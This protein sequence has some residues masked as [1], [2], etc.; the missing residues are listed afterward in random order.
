MANVICEIQH[1]KTNLSLKMY[2]L[3]LFAFFRRFSEEVV[4]DVVVSLQRACGSSNHSWWAF[5][6]VVTHLKHFSKMVTILKVQMSFFITYRSEQMFSIC[7]NMYSW[8]Q[9]TSMR[10]KSR[11]TILQTCLLRTIFKIVQFLFCKV[12]N[13][14]F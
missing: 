1:R 11:K 2:F 4:I 10:W 14:Y 3:L 7:E 8:S 6:Q 9:G 5:P 13:I 12:I